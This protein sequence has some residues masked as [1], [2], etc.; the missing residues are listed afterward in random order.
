V[1][2]PLP[3]PADTP[4]PRPHYEEGKPLW[5]DVSHGQEPEP[6]LVQRGDDGPYLE[7]SYLGPFPMSWEPQERPEAEPFLKCPNCNGTG[8]TG[9]GYDGE[10]NECHYCEDGRLFAAEFIRQRDTL[11]ERVGDCMSHEVILAEK[12]A[13]IARLRQPAALPEGHAELMR[14]AAETLNEA[15]AMC[16]DAYNATGHVKV[17]RSSYQRERL[18]DVAARLR[19]AAGGE[20]P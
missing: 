9:V 3:P 16:D 18:A 4:K 11:E 1:S 19:A 2:D 14:T 13:E 20:T 10:V 17:A 6:F 8:E 12:D 15:V 5:F 7:G